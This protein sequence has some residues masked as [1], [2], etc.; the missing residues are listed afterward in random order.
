MLI[1]LMLLITAPIEVNWDGYDYYKP[2]TNNF[3][4]RPLGWKKPD[5]SP[6]YELVATIIG[7]DNKYIKAYIRDVRYD[8]DYFV[9]IGDN[10]GSSVVEEIHRGLVQLDGEEI[11]GDTFGLLNTSVRKR[12]NTR[13][14]S[15]T[16]TSS[17]TSTKS[18]ETKKEDTGVRQRTSSGRTGGADWQ[19]RM[20][21]FQNASPEERQQMIEQFRSRRGSRGGGRGRG[22][23]R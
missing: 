15:S 18:T 21:Q 9:G 4:F 6:K 16:S 11:K 3:L 5:S 8:R 22:R 1:L 2:I 7:K 23:N 13:K 20:S 17:G 14:G 19:A 12:T 10:V